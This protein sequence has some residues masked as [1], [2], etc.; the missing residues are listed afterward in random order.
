MNAMLPV[1][2]IGAARSSLGMLS[3]SL[4]GA[5]GGWLYGLIWAQRQKG[6]N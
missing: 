1:T 5:L 3:L 6:Q 2:V 4:A